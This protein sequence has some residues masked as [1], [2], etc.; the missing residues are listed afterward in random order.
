MGGW[1][2]SGDPCRKRR[3][4]QCSLESKGIAVTVLV[5]SCWFQLKMAEL[6]ISASASL[7]GS[8]YEMNL[9]AIVY[10]SRQTF[11]TNVLSVDQH[12]DVRIQRP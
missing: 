12:L 10:F 7:G 11:R 1:Y 6:A 3:W 2:A 8:E 4:H 9:I 5:R